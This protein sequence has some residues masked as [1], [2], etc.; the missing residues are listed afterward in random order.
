MCH[1]FFSE[2]LLTSFVRYR[3]LTLLQFLRTAQTMAMATTLTKQQSFWYVRLPRGYGI[4]YGVA[5][6]GEVI[7]QTRLAP[8][9]YAALL[10]ACTVLYG[11]GREPKP[12]FTVYRS[13]VLELDCERSRLVA[14]AIAATIARSLLQR[15][16]R[17]SRFGNC[18][19]QA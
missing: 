4:A 15:T 17:A 16:A 14:V 6:L 1:N 11:Q 18:P 9:V 8:E 13:D 5:P 10:D 3:T 7:A 19:T 12:G 2:T